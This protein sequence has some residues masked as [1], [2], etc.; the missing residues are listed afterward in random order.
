M[1]HQELWLSLNPKQPRKPCVKPVPSETLMRS[2]GD[3][4]PTWGTVQRHQRTVSLWLE[5][6][7]GRQH[8]SAPLC[9]LGW[10]RRCPN[11]SSAAALSPKS[12][13]I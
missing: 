11:P 3:P 13:D 10:R 9:I 8:V 4:L 7:G 5:W 1:F 2:P 12:A 6:G